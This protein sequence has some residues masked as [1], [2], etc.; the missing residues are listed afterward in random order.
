MLILPLLLSIRVDLKRE[1]AVW[2]KTAASLSSY[3]KDESTVRNT[4]LKRTTRLLG[5]LN[6]KICNKTQSVEDYNINLY[7]LMQEVINN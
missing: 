1:I 5:K 7:N 4:L 3:S 6:N 2:Q